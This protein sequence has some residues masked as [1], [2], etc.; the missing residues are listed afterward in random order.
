MVFSG[1]MPSSGIAGSYG[2]FIPNFLRTLHTVLHSGCI[3]VHFQQQSKRVPFSPN[4]L[5][6]LMFVDF[7]FKTAILTGVR[8]YP[9]VVSIFIGRSQHNI[10][11]QLSSIKNKFKNRMA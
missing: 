4:P 6:H 7:F 10:T 1:Y 5:Q 8:W 3:N 2:S 9:I 11:N